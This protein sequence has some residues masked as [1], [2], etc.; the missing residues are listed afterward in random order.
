MSP[1]EEYQKLL[2]EL[3]NSDLFKKLRE[4][5]SKIGRVPYITDWQTY[6][7]DPEEEAGK[8]TSFGDVQDNQHVLLAWQK[9]V[10]NPDSRHPCHNFKNGYYAGL[11]QGVDD[12]QEYI[13][14]LS[15]IVYESEVELED[16]LDFLYKGGIPLVQR[17]DFGK[18]AYLIS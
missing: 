18:K 17:T 15:D 14:F 2:K 10:K 3:E 11:D 1:K 4:V 5:G 16:L 7:P 13:R 9:F 8:Y 12:L 6:Q